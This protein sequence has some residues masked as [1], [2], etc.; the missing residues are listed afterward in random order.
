MADEHIDRFGDR[1]TVEVQ[2]A[3]LTFGRF[4]QRRGGWTLPGIV[5]DK[6]TDDHVGIQ[7]QFLHGFWL[8]MRVWRA[9][10]A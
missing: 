9:Q 6:E 10:A 3:L 4:Q 7:Q 5:L 1:Q 8:A 2:S